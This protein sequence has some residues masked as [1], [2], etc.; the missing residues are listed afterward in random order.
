M[1]TILFLLIIFGIFGFLSL[2][3]PSYYDFSGLAEVCFVSEKNYDFE[4]IISTENENYITVSANEGAKA[5]KIIDEKCKVLIFKN[6]SL[7]GIIGDFGA[8][9]LKKEV[10]DNMVVSYAYTILEDDYILLENKKI[11]MQI[12]EKG[13]CIKVGLP[14]ILGSF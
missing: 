8:K 2:K 12:V 14:I 13:D 3:E 7:E 9:I 10:V 11:N 5:D 1:K 6:R 4:N